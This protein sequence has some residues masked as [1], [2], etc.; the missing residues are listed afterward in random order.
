MS[1]T[2]GVQ[3]RSLAAQL[4]PPET[5][6]FIEDV[7]D[8][9]PPQMI[10]D[11]LFSYFMHGLPI[12]DNGADYDQCTESISSIIQLRK[13]QPEDPLPIK[14]DALPMCV[15]GNCGSY[16]DYKSYGRLSTLNDELMM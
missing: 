5:T 1:L 6:S 15:I 11:A 9:N 16:L 10:I 2:K 8:S 7:A 4:T 12:K 3:F 13:S 14:F